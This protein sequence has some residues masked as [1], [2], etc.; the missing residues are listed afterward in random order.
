ME[1]HKSLALLIPGLDGTGLLYCRQIEKLEGRFRPLPWSFRERSAFD[2]EDLVAELGEGTASEPAG[3]I[4]VVGESFGGPIAILYAL[5]YPGRVKKLILI[6]AFPYYRRRLRIG[7]ACLLVPLLRRKICRRVKDLVAEW[8]LRREGIRKPDIDLYHDIVRR[9]H[10]PAFRRRLQLVR[11]LDLRHRLREIAAPTILLAAGR[12]KLVPSVHEARYMAGRIPRAIVHEF[13]R[14]G[15]AL[16][17][18]PGF[19]LA[20]YLEEGMMTSAALLNQETTDAAEAR[21][22]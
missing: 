20:D 12:D 8:I 10:L 7:L 5:A 6:N 18:T 22:V 17:L 1:A 13:P 11:Q 16:L 19:R 14:A 3:S 21:E 9:V 15:H 2:L 4:A